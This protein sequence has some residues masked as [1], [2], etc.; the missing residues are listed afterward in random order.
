LV[1]LRRT[2]SLI[3]LMGADRDRN[4]LVP[5]KVTLVDDD[6]C[7]AM[8]GR[9]NH[10]PI[11]PADL[12]VGRLNMLAAT[13]LHVA[14]GDTVLGDGLRGRVADATHLPDFSACAITAHDFASEA[15]LRSCGHEG[16]LSSGCVS[17]KP[18][19]THLGRATAIK[20]CD[21]PYGEARPA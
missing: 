11:Y 8:I 6:V 19:L 21:G 3:S 17:P 12:A 14:F 20:T 15:E 16:R 5:A 1:V 10:E 9:V 4:R 18:P 7:E 13:H 2:P